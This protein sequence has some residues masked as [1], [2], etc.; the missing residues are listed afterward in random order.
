MAMFALRAAA[1]LRAAQLW[2]REL[3]PDEEETVSRPTSVAEKAQRRL[4]RTFGFE[5]QEGGDSNNPTRRP[6]RRRPGW[7]SARERDA[8]GDCQTARSGSLLL[9]AGCTR[10]MLVADLMASCFRLL[11]VE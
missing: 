9:S 5:A 3:S 1:A 6:S 10:C 2:L 7:H 8:A 4:S 11:R